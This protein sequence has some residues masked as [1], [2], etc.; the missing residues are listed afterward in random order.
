VAVFENR[1]LAHAEFQAARIALVKTVLLDAL[2]MLLAGLGAHAL[3]LANAVAVFA[4]RANRA[5]RP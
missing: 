4:L 2:R 1:T 3:E 5:M